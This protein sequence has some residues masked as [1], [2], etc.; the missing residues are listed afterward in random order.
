MPLI[1]TKDPNDKP[2]IDWKRK[3]Y[4][5]DIRTEDY[6][7]GIYERAC[8]K[9]RRVGRKTTTAQLRQLFP[10]QRFIKQMDIP[11]DAKQSS[12][13]VESWHRLHTTDDGQR[14]YLRGPTA[15]PNIQISE[16]A[17]KQYWSRE[18]KPAILDWFAIPVW[19]DIGETVRYDPAVAVPEG[20]FLGD[21]GFAP[22][23]T[24]GINIDTGD[25]INQGGGAYRLNTFVDNS[26]LRPEQVE[27][28]QQLLEQYKQRRTHYE[29]YRS[30]RS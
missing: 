17:V 19:A 21:I 10:T 26:L 7:A 5:D 16:H 23:Q 22:N 8:L 12:D 24:M 28:Q 27:L 25:S 4:I 6:C 3:Y 18:G 20:L 30:K 9:I 29:Q 14:L 1:M 15:T 2:Y 13:L 11:G